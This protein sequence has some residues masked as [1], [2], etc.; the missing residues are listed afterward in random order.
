MPSPR[1]ASPEL[2][3][4][5]DETVAGINTTVNT[6]IPESDEPENRL[7]E[8]MRYA[9]LEGGKRIRPFL[10]IE[11]AK[12]FGV[13]HLR[14]KRVGAALE[15]VHAYSLV[16]DDLPAM[17]DADLR[18]GKPSVHKKFDEATAILAGDALLTLAF[19]ILAEPETHEDPRVRCELITLL[20]RSAGMTGMVGGQM[21]D[22][23]GEKAQ[24]DVGQIS[25]LHRMK[26][27]MLMSFACE[28]GAILGKADETRR[29]A[30]RSYAFD[31]GLAFQ[32]TDDILDV[33][34]DPAETGKEKGKDAQSGKSTFVTTLGHEQAKMRAEMLVHQAIRH[35]HVFDQRAATLKAFAMY[36][37]ERRA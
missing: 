32:V 23:I 34:G 22:L 17:D 31:L 7:N 36:V 33:E 30:L 13:D 14:A 2:Q 27:G 24:F 37:L 3:R 19:E 10:V 6:L 9:T 26:T 29:K 12:L 1:E 18:R 20:A 35:L 5:L 25:R 4:A 8:A 28:A 16:H 11:C 15:F 21:L